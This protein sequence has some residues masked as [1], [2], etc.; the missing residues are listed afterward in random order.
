MGDDHK[1][2]VLVILLLFISCL[3]VTG[4][5]GHHVYNVDTMQLECQAQHGIWNLAAPRP[6]SM[7]Q[8]YTCFWD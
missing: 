6:G 1:I 7:Q 2:V 5:I 4:V 3:I 8:V